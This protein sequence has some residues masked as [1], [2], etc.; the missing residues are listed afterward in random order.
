MKWLKMELFII[1]T[2][3]LTSDDLAKEISELTGDKGLHFYDA[4]APIVS[5][6]FY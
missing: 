1:A 6:R 5:K 3:P 2:G 4:A